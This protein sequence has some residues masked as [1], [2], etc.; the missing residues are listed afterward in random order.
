MPHIEQASASRNIKDSTSYFKIVHSVHSLYQ[1]TPFITSLS[2]HFLFVL[3]FCS[4]KLSSVFVESVLQGVH[5]NFEFVV[6]SSLHL[7][8]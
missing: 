6:N 7:F 4:R 8:P 2:R 5:H 1:R 3:F